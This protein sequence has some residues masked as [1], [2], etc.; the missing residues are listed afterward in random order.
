VRYDAS[1]EQQQLAASTRRFIEHTVPLSTVR[2]WGDKNPAGFDLDWWRRAADLGWTALLVPEGMG[3]ATASG[4]G[5]ADL[6]LVAE[7]CGRLVSPG[8]LL[9]SSVAAWTLAQA[10]GPVPVRGLLG[11]LVAGD[12]LWAWAVG[13]TASSFLRAPPSLRATPDGEDLVLDGTARVVES[14]AD[15][16][17]LLI[18]VALDHGV[19]H[20]VVPADVVGLRRVRTAGLDLV[21][22][23]ADLTCSGVVVP[24]TQVIIG[25][26]A[27]G[28]VLRRQTQIA[29]IVQ[30]AEM[31]GAAEH[32]FA[33]TLDYAA[34]RW[35]FG[36]PLSS[37]QVLKH[38]LADMKL[39]LE[40]S[41]AAVEGAVDAFHEG[42]DVAAERASA[43]KLYVAQKM[44]DLVQDCVQIHGGIGVTWE[45]DLHLYLRRVTTDRQLIG[46]PADHALQL[47]ALSG[48]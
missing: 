11:Q 15:A 47:A 28:S 40:A 8:P 20:L 18:A 43:A 9:P 21:R 5:L 10:D 30:C 27:G 12:A 19:A 33:L 16:E 31:V 22:R 41:H 36:R 44:V 42:G 34:D 23:Y 26:E 37:Y 1:E 48:L 46:T 35:S 24:A 29:N 13:E 45:H 2:L 6:A 17:Y 32:V 25:A 14:G 38:R 3:G 4:D 39:W 7:E